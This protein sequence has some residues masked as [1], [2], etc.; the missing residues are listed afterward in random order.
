MLNHDDAERSLPPT[1]KR[2]REARQ[3][4]Q[5][6]RSPELTASVL[7]LAA[8]LL[9]WS[10]APTWAAL[11]ISSL[12]KSINASGQGILATPTAETLT[13]G[14]SGILV[15]VLLPFFAT[16][17][18]VGLA[19]NLIQT[20]WVWNPGAIL[21]RWQMPRIAPWE[22]TTD[23]TASLLRIVVLAGLVWIYVSRQYAVV[24][25]LGEGEPATMLVHSVRLI[26]ELFIQVSTTLVLFGLIN[27]GVCYWRHEKRLMMTPEERRRE[28]KDDEVDPRVK[29]QRAAAA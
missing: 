5:V 17:F 16:V 2:R 13:E 15:Q 29:K 3:Q 28:Q 12:Q 20:G 9:I 1:D 25:S 18:L 26:G 11:L 19:A 21:P 14:V 23:F 10:N 7:M 8:S 4:G 6:A 24:L 22:R 27:Y